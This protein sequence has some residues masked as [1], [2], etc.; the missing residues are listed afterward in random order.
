[1]FQGKH[2][3]YA[4]EYCNGLGHGLYKIVGKQT[5]S[6]HAKSQDVVHNVKKSGQLGFNEITASLDIMNS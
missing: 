3:N 6:Y 4:L 2:W 1:M 5:E